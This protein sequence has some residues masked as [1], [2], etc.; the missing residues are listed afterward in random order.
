M[1]SIQE[2]I[3]DY[4]LEEAY[5]KIQEIRNSHVQERW[6]N[7]LDCAYNARLLSFG[8][9]EYDEYSFVIQESER[10]A[11]Q[12]VI[13]I[14]FKLLKIYDNDVLLSATLNGDIRDI[15]M[16]NT[17]EKRTLFVFKKFGLDQS[18]PDEL[19]KFRMNQ[20]GANDYYYVSYVWDYA[21][22]EAFDRSDDEEFGHGIKRISIQELFLKYVSEGE[23]KRFKKN[24]EAFENKVK[25][26]IGLRVVKTL[27]PSTLYRFK[28]IVRD[29]LKNYMYA[30]LVG[31]NI[32][33][34]QFD[35][36]KKQFI[37]KEVYTAVIENKVFSDS[38]ITA[39]WL[40]DSYKNAGRIDYTFVVLGY[41]KSIEQMLY[42]YILLHV[43]EKYNLKRKYIEGDSK[44]TY[45]NK[46]GKEKLRK[47]VPINQEN[48]DEDRLD[49][50]LGTMISGF[51]CS[52][53]NI[54]KLIRKDIDSEVTVPYIEGILRKVKTLRNGNF[55]KHNIS[56]K[57]AEKKV[58]E[59]RDI[60]YLTFFLV[61]GAYR[62]RSSKEK[63][64]YSSLS[65]KPEKNRS[66]YQKLCEY[67]M[68]HPHRVFYFDEQNRKPYIC[69]VDANYTNDGK[70]EYGKVVAREA[71][72]K[73]IIYI[74]SNTIPSKIDVGWIDLKVNPSIN[75]INFSGPQFVVIKDGRFCAKDGGKI[76]LY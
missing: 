36:I 76:P 44:Y 19:L 71:E 4:H 53:R 65:V 24:I 21:Y 3:Y 1:T 6:E 16:V 41:F 9:N 49:T 61:L 50:T 54:K 64:D 52:E 48:I 45:T 34:D 47:Y 40:Y 29:S 38:F 56:E 18:L 20:V 27:H 62:L 17:N 31:D 68:D 39:E 12:E 74:D 63:D 69:K 70:C 13:Q 67:I 5:K 33:P 55:H 15:L 58:E 59:A 35:L 72:G 73:E 60:T 25:E 8:G 32:K 22:L 23:Y 30:E 66:E 7:D 46:E 75:G 11:Q 57:E 14:I 28:R 42:A 26:Y 2:H 51:F 43:G 10:I 37:K